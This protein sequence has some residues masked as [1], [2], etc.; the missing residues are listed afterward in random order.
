MLHSSESKQGLTGVVGCKRVHDTLP[1][2]P[3]HACVL[4]LITHRGHGRVQSKY[5][6]GPGRL[7]GNSNS[8]KLAQLQI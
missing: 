2:C 1:F 8:S 3:L 7:F 5:H 4:L 6:E